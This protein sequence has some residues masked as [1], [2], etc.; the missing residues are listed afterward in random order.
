MHGANRRAH[1]RVDQAHSAAAVTGQ[2]AGGVDVEREPRDRLGPYG[3]LLC[4]GVSHPC[5]AV[6]DGDSVGGIDVAC[7]GNVCDEV[8]PLSQGL[9]VAAGAVA[10]LTH[11]QEQKQ[12]FQ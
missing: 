6:R 3:G 7:I 2:V 10:V 8:T 12:V 1:Q 4:H 5:C 11:L 9:E